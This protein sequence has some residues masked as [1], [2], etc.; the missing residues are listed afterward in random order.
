MIRHPQLIITI[1]LLL[2]IAGCRDSSSALAADAKISGPPVPNKEY[3]A[4]NPRACEKVTKAPSV[5]EA[6]ALV[7]CGLEG[8]F[9]GPSLYLVTDVKIEM[10]APRNQTPLDGTNDLDPRSKIYPLRG[11]LTSYSCGLVAQYGGGNQLPEVAGCNRRRRTRTL[12]AD[13][14]WRLEVHF[15][16]RTCTT[17]HTARGRAYRLL[18]HPG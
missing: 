7:Q 5:A 12:L 11:S 18:G 15:D 17:I 1:G 13:F 10:G 2:A 6:Q 9:P 4:R 8:F 3:G 16:R 14:L